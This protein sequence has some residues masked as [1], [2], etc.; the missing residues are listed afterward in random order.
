MNDEIWWNFILCSVHA[1]EGYTVPLEDFVLQI[2]FKT[3]SRRVLVHLYY[4]IVLYNKDL[5]H[6]LHVLVSTNL[7]VAPLRLHAPTF[8]NTHARLA[9]VDVSNNLYTLTLHFAQWRMYIYD[10]LIAVIYSVRKLPDLELS[11]TFRNKVATAQ[12]LAW[13]R[14][15]DVIYISLFTGKWVHRLRW[16]ISLLYMCLR[17]L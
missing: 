17:R 5:Q 16:T 8:H 10:T 9:V 2:F 15:W 7:P 13:V 12:K 4:I 1:W 14:F 6:K 11:L 3:S